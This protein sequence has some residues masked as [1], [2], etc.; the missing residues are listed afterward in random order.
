M[1]VLVNALIAEVY[2]R[3]VPAT[4]LWLYAL[5][6]IGHFVYAFFGREIRA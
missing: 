2:E 1:I 5:S 6:G 3:T 4:L